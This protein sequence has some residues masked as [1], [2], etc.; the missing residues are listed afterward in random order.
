MLQ[1]TN[2]ANVEAFETL[3][4]RFNRFHN[5]YGKALKRQ[6]VFTTYEVLKSSS[7]T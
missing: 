7:M 6:S 5:I 1:Q 3:K 2:P 4:I